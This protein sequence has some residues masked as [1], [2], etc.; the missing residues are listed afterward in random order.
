MSL[1]F[2]AINM[3]SIS[4]YPIW[5]WSNHV[6]FS[7][8]ILLIDTIQIFLSTKKQVWD[9][10]WQYNNVMR[11][12]VKVGLRLRFFAM[13]L[14]EQ[15]QSLLVWLFWNAGFVF[16][17]I[18]S[19][20]VTTRDSLNKYS[21]STRCSVSYLCWFSSELGITLSRLDVILSLERKLTLFSNRH[22]TGLASWH[23]QKYILSA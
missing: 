12:T 3:P 14:S 13:A 15:A 4:L 20:S 5:G 22:K 2:Y 18:L 16:V 11:L 21:L 1:F 23:K 19:S 9:Y 17:L 10:L 8:P 7:P 6:Y